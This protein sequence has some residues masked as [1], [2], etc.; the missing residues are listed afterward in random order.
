M[1]KGYRIGGA[2]VSEKHAGFIINTGGAGA[3]VALVEHIK[4]VIV[5]NFG[6]EPV[7]EIRFVGR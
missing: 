2:A 5:K 7:C 1:A 4:A 6:F 3:D